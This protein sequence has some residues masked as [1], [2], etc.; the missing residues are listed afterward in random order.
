MPKQMK[1][2]LGEIQAC[3]KQLLEED[4]AADHGQQIS[5]EQRYALSSSIEIIE[6]VKNISPGLRTAVDQLQNMKKEG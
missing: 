1:L 5:A 6:F 2:S 4:L 3:I